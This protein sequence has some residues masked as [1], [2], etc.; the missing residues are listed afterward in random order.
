MVI[1][2]QVERLVRASGIGSG[3]VALCGQGVGAAIFC[4]E[5]DDTKLGQWTDRLTEV[6]AKQDPEF[7]TQLLS[8]LYGQSLVLPIERSTLIHDSWQQIV[9]VDFGSQPRRRLI[10]VQMLGEK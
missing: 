2:G 4:L 10:S 3:I 9:V 1:T 7:S 5:G 8:Q 6:L